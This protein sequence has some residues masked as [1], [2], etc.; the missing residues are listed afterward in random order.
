MPA[1]RGHRS[2]PTTTA[3]LRARVGAMLKAHRTARDAAEAEIVE[4][5]R[6]IIADVSARRVA[7][8][9][10]PLTP[11]QEQSMLDDREARRVK[12]T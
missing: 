6:K 2:S 10:P 11:D 4:H 1:R 5:D 3:Q 12:G 7:K 9:K 8:G